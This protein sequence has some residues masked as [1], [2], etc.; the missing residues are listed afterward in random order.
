MAVIDL[1]K[2]EVKADLDQIAAELRS[3]ER[4]NIVIISEL[5][6][7][8]DDIE[9]DLEIICMGIPPCRHVKGMLIDGLEIL[10]ELTAPD[11]IDDYAQR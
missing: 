2:D 9:G 11:P 8:D 7:Q 3:G 4:Q 10:S 5:A 1:H 6:I